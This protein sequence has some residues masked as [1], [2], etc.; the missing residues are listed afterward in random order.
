MPE[1]AWL[2]P[3]NLFSEAALRPAFCGRWTKLGSLWTWWAAPLSA[4]SWE[5]CMQRRRA[6]VGWGSGL[7]SGLWYVHFIT[8]TFSYLLKQSEIHIVLQKF[9]VHS[10]LTSSG[11]VQGMT[12]Y[13]KKILDLTYPVTSMFSGA[14]FNYSISSVFKDKQIEVCFFTPSL[15]Q[16]ETG[17]LGNL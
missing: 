3:V 5:L 12:S 8:D 7:G 13:F 4:L 16:M 10:Y 15:S 14:S 9:L 1:D 11:F 17:V 2:N 6:A